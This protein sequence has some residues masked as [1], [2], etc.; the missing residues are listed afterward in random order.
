MKNEAI[1][2]KYP[3]IYMGF[4]I[5]K[6]SN[7]RW[8]RWRRELHVEINDAW[9]RA[10]HGYDSNLLWDMREH[11]MKTIITGLLEL[12]EKGNSVPDYDVIGGSHDNAALSYDETD[13]LTNER[14]KEWKKLLKDLADEFYDLLMFSDQKHELNQYKD[15]LHKS[16]SFEEEK[17][18]P[19]SFAFVLADG[20]TQ[21]Q[22]ESLSSAYNEREKEIMEYKSMKEKAA[23][24]RL[25]DILPFLWN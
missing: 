23:M 12:A 1:K 16:Y 9:R 17:D 4:Q 14:L 24:E 11:L 2:S 19:N 21:E 6:K 3:G 18:D 15:E 25:T 5:P 13:E 10:A 20:Y 22:Y 8:R 7:K